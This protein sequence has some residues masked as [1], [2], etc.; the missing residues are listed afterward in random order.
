MNKTVLRLEITRRCGGGS[1]PTLMTQPFSPTNTVLTSTS[2]SLTLIIKYPYSS[3]GVAKIRLNI[4]SGLTSGRNVF[5]L[6][7]SQGANIRD[8]IEK[9]RYSEE[10]NILNFRSTFLRFF[11]LLLF[12]LSFIF[13]KRKLI[14]EN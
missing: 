13:L 7:F 4:L 11:Q 10:R 12:N 3:R 6:C 8:I 14:P 2:T 1:S 5:S 9:N